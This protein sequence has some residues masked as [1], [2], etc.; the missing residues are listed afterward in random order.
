MFAFDIC[1]GREE[2]ACPGEH[3]E[4]CLRMLIEFSQCVQDILIHGLVERIQRVRSIELNALVLCLVRAR[5]Y[6]N[7][8]NLAVNFEADSLVVRRHCAVQGVVTCIS[9]SDMRQRA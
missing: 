8:A 4:H 5:A 1:A 7:D 2:P 9:D 3:G 6:P